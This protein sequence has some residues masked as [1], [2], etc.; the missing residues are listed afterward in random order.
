[1][2]KPMKERRFRGLGLATVVAVAAI[3]LTPVQ[4]LAIEPLYVHAKNIVKGLLDKAIIADVMAQTAE[5]KGRAQERIGFAIFNL[6]RI[7]LEKP[8]GLY[9]PLK[10]AS[11]RPTSGE[12]QEMLGGAIL[13]AALAKTREE[14]QLTQEVLGYLL[15]NKTSVDLNESSLREDVEIALG[16]KKWNGSLF[17]TMRTGIPFYLK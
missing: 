10:R 6:A 8:K 7:D 15:A 3:F 5:E 13:E 14:I 12:I 9:V 16:V 4:A 1:M 2:Y 17:V 11:Y